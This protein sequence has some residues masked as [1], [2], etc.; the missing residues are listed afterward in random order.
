[1][2]TRKIFGKL[3]NGKQS[4]LYE[5]S[6]ANGMQVGVTEIGCSIVTLRVPDKSGG[7]RDVVFGFNNPADY[8]TNK[9][10]FGCAVG[11]VAN[12]I[13]SGKFELDGKKYELEK[14]DHG[15]HH[16]HGGSSGYALRQWD[17]LPYDP[18]GFRLEFSL[19]SPDG[20][21]GY[22]GRLNV[23]VA[24]TL[25]QDNALRIDYHAETDS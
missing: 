11:R 2:I 16:L 20:D 4:C 5:M 14:N 9:A 23:K 25:L 18:D 10:Y 7:L 12:R 15:A 6:N 1:M 21:A 22:P 3:K 24:Y 19:I 13:A 17:A 8:V